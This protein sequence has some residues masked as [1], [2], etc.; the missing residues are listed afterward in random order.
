MCKHAQLA[1]ETSTQGHI[2]LTAK[3]AEATHWDKMC[4]DLIGSYMICRKKGSN[5]KNVLQSLN[6]V[7]VGLK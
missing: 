2:W 1:K 5:V 7:L 3:E 6:K 4:N